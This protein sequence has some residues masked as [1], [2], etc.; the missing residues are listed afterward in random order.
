MP[1][2]T[3]IR[4]DQPVGFASHGG[5]GDDGGMEARLKRIEDVLPS[6][7]T[8]DEM[9]LGFAELRTEMH[10]GFNEQVMWIV[11]TAIALGV[12]GITVMTFVLNNAVPKQPAPQAQPTVIVVPAAAAPPASK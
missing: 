10:K 11:G 4:P 6:L 5:G 8:R 7:A 12:A 1:D 3:P 9:K 2:P